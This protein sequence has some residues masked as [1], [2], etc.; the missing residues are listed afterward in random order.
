M[1]NTQVSAQPATCTQDNINFHGYKNILIQR[2]RPLT[3]H[4]HAVAYFTAS[5]LYAA[6]TFTRCNAAAIAMSMATAAKAIAD[7]NVCKLERRADT[8]SCSNDMAATMLTAHCRIA[9]VRAACNACAYPS[10]PLSSRPTPPKVRFVPTAV[11]A[12]TTASNL[13]VSGTFTRC[14]ADAVAQSAAAV[15][16]AGGDMLAAHQNIC[17]TRTACISAGDP[18]GPALPADHSGDSPLTN[19]NSNPSRI[20]NHDHHTNHTVSS[21]LCKSCPLDL[22]ESLSATN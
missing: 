20:R 12:Y 19:S 18:P 15:A 11:A 1:R 10:A 8:S 21:R 13:F 6:A 17:T 4:L 9:A 22:I 2:S 16:Y 3:T 14:N 5:D 7:F